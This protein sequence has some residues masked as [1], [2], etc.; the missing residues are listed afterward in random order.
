MS[1]R[2]KVRLEYD[3]DGD[4]VVE[5]SGID[6]RAWETEY[7]QSALDAR[8][9]VSMLTW[10]GHHAAVRQGLLDAELKDYQAFDQ[11]CASVEGVPADRPPKAA[12]K[13]TRKAPGDGSSAP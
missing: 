11:V 6:L 1:L 10:L 12:A 4:L 13:S 2:Q 8:M 9:S 7:G 5:Y 3:H